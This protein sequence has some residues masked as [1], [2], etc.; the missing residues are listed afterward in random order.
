[1]HLKIIWVKDILFEIETET[2]SCGYFNVHFLPFEFGASTA[3]SKT[4]LE[5]FDLYICRIK[6]F[7]LRL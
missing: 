7:I 1:M 3:L 6:I 4:I 5:F 2:K